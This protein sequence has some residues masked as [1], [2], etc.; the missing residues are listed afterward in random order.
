SVPGPR[1]SKTKRDLERARRSCRRRPSSARKCKRFEVRPPEDLMPHAIRPSGRLAPDMDATQS[2]I[3][4]GGGH[5][6]R[7][8]AEAHGAIA[9]FQNPLSGHTPEQA[10]HAGSP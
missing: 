5:V 6:T 8:D 4:I 1:S 2:L 9:T 10:A 7:D 3:E